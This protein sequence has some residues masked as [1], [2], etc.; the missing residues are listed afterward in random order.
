MEYFFEGMSAFQLTALI[1]AMFGHR[2]QEVLQFGVYRVVFHFLLG[3]NRY[4][5]F[6]II[7]RRAA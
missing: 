6:F 4:F 3:I 1:A 5:S 2:G 7:S